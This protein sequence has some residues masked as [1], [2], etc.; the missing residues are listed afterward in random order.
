[1]AKSKTTPGASSAKN[2]AT[3]AAAAEHARLSA[4][5]ARHDQL[6]HAADAPVISDAAYDQLRRQLSEL[7]ARDPLLV[8]ADSPSV[9]VGA[10]PVE[11]FGKVRHGVPML[12]MGFSDQ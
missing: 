12:S 8:T 7:E 4:E 3:L 9:R 11:G 5:I 2:S 6:Y 1:M 10:A